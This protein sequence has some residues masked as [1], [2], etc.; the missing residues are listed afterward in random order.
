[1]ES[2]LTDAWCPLDLTVRHQQEQIDALLRQP[3]QL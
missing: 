3:S 1:M 2:R